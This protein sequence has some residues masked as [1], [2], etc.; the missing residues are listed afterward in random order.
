M[1]LLDNMAERIN[2]TVQAAVPEPCV[3]I[4][5]LQPAGTTGA[6]GLKQVSGALGMFRQHKAN[7]AAGALSERHGLKFNALT[8]FALTPDK[9][10]VLDAK[11]KRTNVEIRS[12]LAAW[13]RPDVTVQLVPGKVT[14]KVVLDHT[15]GGHYEL[16]ASQLTKHNEPLL[17]ELSTMAR[18]S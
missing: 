18:A 17:A 16:E 7:Q 14:T 6:Y 5:V 3:A 1:G 13:N 2:A 10:Y 8:Y 9:L 15:D 12:T 4:G 11:A